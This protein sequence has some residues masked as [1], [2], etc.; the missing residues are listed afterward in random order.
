[1]LRDI[2]FVIF[3]LFTHKQIYASS[4]FTGGSRGVKAV[5]GFCAVFNAL[6]EVVYLVYFGIKVSVIHAVLLLVISLIVTILSSRITVKRTIRKM[7]QDGW[8]PATDNEEY[9]LATYNRKCD[10][11]A[12]L[13]ADIGIIVNAVIIVLFFVMR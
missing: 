9:F 5:I 13:L 8:N 7:Q 10:V 4:H 3:F 11:A 2:L 6:F 12:T 1:M